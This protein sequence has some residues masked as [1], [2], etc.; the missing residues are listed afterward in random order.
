VERDVPL[1]IPEFVARPIASA[2]D[3]RR[4][5]GSLTLRSV[6]PARQALDPR[7]IRLTHLPFS[8]RRPDDFVGGLAVLYTVQIFVTHIC[9]RQPITDV[10][11]GFWV[12]RALRAIR[13]GRF[14]WAEP[15]VTAVGFVLFQVCRR[16]VYR[17][18]SRGLEVPRGPSAAGNPLP[19]PIRSWAWV[20][21]LL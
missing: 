3:R 1:P 7:R 18:C 6:A 4:S 8:E 20:R 14:P 21:D 9:E 15:A 19:A 11:R 17:R 13:S 10:R 5:W 12:F 16:A 2:R